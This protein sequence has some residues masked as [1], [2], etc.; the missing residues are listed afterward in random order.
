MAAAIQQ[1]ADA[2][3]WAK[4]HAAPPAAPAGSRGEH[5]QHLGFCDTTQQPGPGCS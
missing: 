1:T 4:L 3:H 5:Q 2:I